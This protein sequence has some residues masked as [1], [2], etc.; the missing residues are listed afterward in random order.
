MVKK[1]ACFCAENGGSSTSESPVT[2]HQATTY[3]IPEDSNLRLHLH[4]EAFTHRD[5][6]T[7]YGNTCTAD[8]SAQQFVTNKYETVGLQVGY[9]IVTCVVL[10][11]MV[12]GCECSKRT[13]CLP[14]HGRNPS[15]YKE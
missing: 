14:L 12:S 10:C 11:S 7:I 8:V 9:T 3:Y 13:C 5:R 15:T 1:I 6:K 4:G 2:S